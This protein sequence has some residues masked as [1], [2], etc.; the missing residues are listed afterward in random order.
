MQLAN[1]MLTLRQAS[2]LHSCFVFWFWWKYLKHSL[3]VSY[4]HCLGVIGLGKQSVHHN[5]FNEIMFVLQREQKPVHSLHSAALAVQSTHNR[6]Q[7]NDCTC[8]A[9]EMLWNDMETSSH[10]TLKSF[11][12]RVDASKAAGVN[13]G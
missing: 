13:A 11:Q 2:C 4:D 12:N 3:W 8:S 9:N 10:S 7:V 6:P 5:R 1:D